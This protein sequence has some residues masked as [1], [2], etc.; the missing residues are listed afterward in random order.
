MPPKEEL[1]LPKWPINRQTNWQVNYYRLLFWDIISQALK[2]KCVFQLRFEDRYSKPTYCFP[3]YC[4]IVG[5]DNCSP[6][7]LCLILLKSTCSIIRLMSEVHVT[8]K[9]KTITIRAQT[10]VSPYAALCQEFLLNLC[11]FLHDFYQ[12][13]HFRVSIKFNKNI[14][15]SHESCQWKSHIT[16]NRT[17]GWN[18]Y[19]IRLTLR[20]QTYSPYNQFGPLCTILE[21]PAW[22]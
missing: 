21:F 19:Y 8:L 10:K 2:K 12:K 17:E 9:Y 3:H 7:I 14:I 11:H 1:K 4:K 5:N 13:S 20:A 15:S 16:L 6:L 18:N 22:H